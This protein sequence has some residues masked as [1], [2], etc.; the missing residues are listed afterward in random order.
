VVIAGAVV[1]ALAVVIYLWVV[2]RVRHSK[3]RV[4]LL[5]SYATFVAQCIEAEYAV[6]VADDKN[7]DGGTTGWFGT[8]WIPM[9]FL[10]I[11]IIVTLHVLSYK[12]GRLSKKSSSN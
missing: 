10:N 8:H 11:M 2:G 7:L 12:H 3:L 9:L 5:V 1:I 6:S 4:L